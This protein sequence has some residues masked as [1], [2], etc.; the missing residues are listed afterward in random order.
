MVIGLIQPIWLRKKGYTIFH[1]GLFLTEMC[2]VF[3]LLR[4]YAYSPYTYFTWGLSLEADLRL[5]PAMHTHNRDREKSSGQATQFN[6]WA[7]DRN[8]AQPQVNLSF[9]PVILRNSSLWIQLIGVMTTIALVFTFSNPSRRHSM[10]K[11]SWRNGM[12]H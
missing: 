5:R 10:V 9:C 4:H 6:I 12:G 2:S 3:L 8:S 11:D 7:T 1:G